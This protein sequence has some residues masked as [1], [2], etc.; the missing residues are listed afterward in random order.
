MTAPAYTMIWTTKTNCALSSRKRIARA[1]ITTTRLST[2][3]MGSRNE[4]TPTAPATAIAAAMKKMTIAKLLRSLGI[5]P[6]LHIRRQRFQQLLLG[7]DELLAAGV[8]ELV[9]RAQHYR[10]HRARVLAVATEDAAQHVD[11]VG[12]R[13]ALSGR[14]PFLV[15][16]LGGDHEDAADRARRGAQLAADA[17]L[18]PV[19]VAAQVVAAPVALRPR[20]LVLRVGERDLRPEELGERGLQPAD[21]RCHVPRHGGAP[22]FRFFRQRL[23][24]APQRFR[25]LRLR[26]LLFVRHVTPESP[27]ERSR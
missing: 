9:L 18:E 11:L 13:V 15:A 1:S 19:V 27:R 26:L 17:A 8:R 24:R 22:A 7:V 3:R 4:T 10:L 5:K 2:E 6:G 25:M 14:D 21:Q 20:T 16:V 23:A 12:L